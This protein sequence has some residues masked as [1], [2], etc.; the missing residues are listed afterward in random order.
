MKNILL[1]CALFLLGMLSVQAKEIK[2]VENPYLLASSNWRERIDKVT[3]YDD[4]TRVELIYCYAMPNAVREVEK[5]RTLKADGCEYALLSVQGLQADGL[6]LSDRGLGHVIF[7]FAPLPYGTESADMVDEEGAG[8]YGIRLIEGRSQLAL[9]DSIRNQVL[10]YEQPLP[11][12]EFHYGKAV[13]RG[14]L[15][16]YRPDMKLQ[17]EYKERNMLFHSIWGKPLKVNPD[18]SFV[19]EYELIRPQRLEIRIGLQYFQQVFVVP[20]GQV[21]MWFSLPDIFADYPP[22]YKKYQKPYQPEYVQKVWLSG[23]Y[24]AL[25]TEMERYNAL[26]WDKDYFLEIPHCMTPGEYR[27]FL[28]ERFN[29]KCQRVMAVKEMSAA[30]YQFLMLS[31][32]KE[33]IISLCEGAAYRLAEFNK[34]FPEGKAVDMTLPVDYFDGLSDFNFVHSPYAVLCEYYMSYAHFVGKYL[35]AQ[36][37][38]LPFWTEIERAR[39]LCQSMQKLNP[40]TQEQ[41]LELDSIQCAAIKEFVYARNEQVIVSWERMMADGGYT[42]HKID[43]G[44]VGKA[45][46]PALLKPFKGKVVLVDLW[47]TWCRPCKQAMKTMLPMKAELKEKGVAFVYLTGPSSPRYTW[48]ELIPTIHEDHYYLTKDQWKYLCDTLNIKVIPAYLVI[49]KQGKVSY[50]HIGDA[51]LD[52]LKAEIIKAIKK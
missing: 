27:R 15:L 19:F 41:R 16:G 9:P 49:D 2:V 52:M 25:N 38:P 36:I 45:I 18:G 50:Q 47:A 23:D 1:C 42:V 33:L 29:R 31:L 37:T 48:E 51:Q 14:H 32:E 40:L 12:P 24:A 20:G 7:T 6:H 28:F 13:I 11:D 39:V 34:A 46:L 3:L 44:V 8:H 30:C 17:V 43:S 4:S 21:E 5:L 10:D 35:S 22:Y 26:I